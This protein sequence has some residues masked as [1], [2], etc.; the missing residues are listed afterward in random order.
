MRALPLQTLV[1]AALCASPARA[2][3]KLLQNDVFPNSGT[4][5]TPVAF[6]DYHGVGAVFEADA[7][8]YPIQLQAI[9]VFCAPSPAGGFPGSSS[10]WLLDVWD[11]TADAGIL[12][13]VKL[14]GNRYASGVQ[15]TSST[16]QFNR[17]TFPQ[18][19]T[20]TSGKFF[21][22]VRD[23][24]G[25]ALND[26]TI[27]MDTGPVKPG[28]NWYYSSQTG[29]SEVTGLPDAGGAVQRQNRNWIVRAV[30]FVDSDAGTGGGAG[31][32]SGGGAGG[33]SGGGLGGGTG[34]SGGGSGGAG[35]AAGGTGGSG[36][37]GGSGG[38]TAGGLALESVTPNEIWAG[39]PNELLIR[40]T[41]F[42]PEVQL[43][44]GTRLVSPI[45]RKSAAIIS[46]ALAPRALNAGVYDVTV[47]NPDGL[48]ATLTQALT[49]KEG[50][51]VP[52]GCGCGAAGGGGLLAAAALLA[53]VRRRPKLRR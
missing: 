22:A 48:D 10:A 3:E 2:D 49:V 24:L 36:G 1:L 27:A 51:A 16:T 18:V 37:A 41:G 6:P 26:T 45:D 12:P 52:S 5:A 39:D 47:I 25:A 4:V 23:Q 20:I 19:I 9:D 53:W 31:G 8:E 15:L 50:V 29:W 7:G 34:G 14:Y 28:A 43:M 40:G 42:A 32:G 30:L 35:G 38:G 13:P 33:G 17:F 11:L 46:V 21:V 44:I